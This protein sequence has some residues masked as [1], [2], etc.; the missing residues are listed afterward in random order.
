MDEKKLTPRE[1]IDRLD[2]LTESIPIQTWIATY[3]ELGE[4]K[5]PLGTGKSF[6]VNAKTKQEAHELAI[7]KLVQ[8]IRRSIIID[9]KVPTITPYTE[10]HYQLKQ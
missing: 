2:K 4:N 1:T 3:Q 7:E 9:Y 8:K 10:Y 5:E 6:T